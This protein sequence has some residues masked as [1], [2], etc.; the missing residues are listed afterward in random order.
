MFE[1]ILFQYGMAGVFIAY[2]IY[3]RQVLLKSFLTEL[4]SAIQDLKNERGGTK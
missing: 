4:K 3:D 1:D 2:L